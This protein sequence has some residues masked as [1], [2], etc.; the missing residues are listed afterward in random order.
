MR[1][2]RPPGCREAGMSSPQAGLAVRLSAAF[3]RL[4]FP[5]SAASIGRNGLQARHMRQA[6]RRVH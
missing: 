6:L 1:A 3:L 4:K 2:L 5:V